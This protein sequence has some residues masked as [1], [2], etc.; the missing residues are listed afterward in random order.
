MTHSLVT[1]L[2][3]VILAALFYLGTAQ[4]HMVGLQKS[5]TAQSAKW[6]QTSILTDGLYVITTDGMS[7]G[8]ADR[9]A[10]GG[11]EPALDRRCALIAYRADA[12]CEPPSNEGIWLISAQGT[13]KRRITTGNDHWPTWS[14]DGKRIAFVRVVQESGP[15]DD[16]PKRS[17]LGI[18]NLR[19][20]NVTFITDD[21]GLRTHPAWSPDGKYIAFTSSTEAS[22]ASC[23]VRLL[24]LERG[25]SKLVPG[26]PKGWC[27]FPSWNPIGHE[28]IL[29]CSTPTYSA[30][31]WS[32]YILLDTSN[33]KRRRLPITGTEPGRAAWSPDGRR[34]AYIKAVSL[35]ETALYIAEPSGHR[36]Q[37]IYPRTRGSK[38]AFSPAW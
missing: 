12:H 30:P 35:H 4:M 38:N 15:A 26:Q 9:S 24:H 18:F 27:A 31:T 28:L 1:P 7:H 5:Q 2:T 20:N 29:W 13:D 11:Y 8:T 32:G 19:T 17:K 34:I 16:Q 21:H 22:S 37:R 14:P 3:R 23:K 25:I 10:F 36:E 6:Q 33:G